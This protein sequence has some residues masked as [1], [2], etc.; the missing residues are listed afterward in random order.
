[1][2]KNKKRAVGRPPAGLGGDKSSAYPL[3]SFRLPP[4]TVRTLRS[5]AAVSGRPQW[6]ILVEALAVY[7][8]ARQRL[9]DDAE[10]EKRRRDGG[11]AATVLD[12]FRDV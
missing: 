2:P 1:M 10:S 5:L 6:R 4:D 12:G 8:T 9:I 3:V 7:E 11:H